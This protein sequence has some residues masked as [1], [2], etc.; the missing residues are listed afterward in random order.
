[1]YRQN[2]LEPTSLNTFQLSFNGKLSEDNRWII[3]AKLIPWEE[4]EQEYAQNFSQEMGA[5][6]KSFRMALGALII[7][8]KLGTSD[9]ETVEQIK[10]NPYLQYFLGMPTYTNE[11]PFD[12]SMFVH[13]RQRIN[14]DLI[15]KINRKMVS[16]QSENISKELD[17]KKDQKAEESEETNKGQLTL[18][19][20]C[21]PADITYPND[22]G[23]LNE[24]REQLEEILDIL[25]E[26]MNEKTNK[27]PRTNRNIARKEYLKVAKKRRVSR[28]ERRKAIKKQLKYIQKNIF[29]IEQLID[30]GASLE[31]LS[32]KQYKMLLVINEVYRQQLWMFE[33]QTHSIQNRIVSLSQTSV[34]LLEEKREY[35]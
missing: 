2:Q 35:L 26:S 20:T 27:K 22:L 28:K 31:T 6:A 29:Y 32:K 18:D 21:A 8:E 3:M 12:A 17:K 24:A 23:L 9:R 11:E 16:N 14:R 25:Y 10:E 5:P 33:N 30:Q 4:F 13:F 34:L 1:M 7:K 15:D 19:A